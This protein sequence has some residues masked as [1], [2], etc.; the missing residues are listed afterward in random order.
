M[1]TITGLW[2][3]SESPLAQISAIAPTRHSIPLSAVRGTSPKL[4]FH[5]VTFLL[6]VVQRTKLQSSPGHF[7]SLEREKSDWIFNTL[8]SRTLFQNFIWLSQSPVTHPSRQRNKQ[9]YL[10]PIFQCKHWA[11]S[12]ADQAKIKGWGRKYTYR[13]KSW[14]P[15]TP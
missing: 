11:S 10:T 13:E 7:Q 1:H 15:M 14:A 2:V 8:Y 4:Y 12:R 5:W 9:L 3:A 6:P